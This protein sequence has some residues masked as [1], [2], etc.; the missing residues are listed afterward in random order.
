MSDIAELDGGKV[1]EIAF[2]NEH[3]LTKFYVSVAPDTG[4]WK[5]AKYEFEFAIPDHY[6]SNEYSST[7][8]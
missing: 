5:G 6:V 8:C 4:Y 7:P 2:P 3:D 1:A